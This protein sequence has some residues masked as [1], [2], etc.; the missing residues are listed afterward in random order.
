MKRQLIVMSATAAKVLYLRTTLGP[1]KQN[2]VPAPGRT[3]CQEIVQARSNF[4][5]RK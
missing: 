4:N 5:E 1:G 2:Y 3:P